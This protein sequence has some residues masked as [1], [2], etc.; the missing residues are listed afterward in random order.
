MDERKEK[1]SI[2]TYKNAGIFSFLAA[3]FVIV[4]GILGNTL[5]LMYMGVIATIQIVHVL[6]HFKFVNDITLS[7]VDWKIFNIHRMLGIIGNGFEFFFFSLILLVGSFSKVE[8]NSPY[9]PLV[10]V[11]MLLYSSLALVSYKITSLKLLISYTK[12]IKACPICGKQVEENWKICP[13]CKTELYNI[14]YNCGKE[15][16]SSWIVCPYCRKAINTESRRDG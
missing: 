11:L 9:F 4:I 2:R 14:C 1:N 10:T 6:I 5:A 12:K 8:W 15:I 3:I 13:Y 16:D 7:K